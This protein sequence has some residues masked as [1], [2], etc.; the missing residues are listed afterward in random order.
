MALDVL[1]HHILPYWRSFIVILTP[2][3]FLPIPIIAGT[4]VNFNRS[5][6]YGLDVGIR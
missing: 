1:K 6:V 2:L 5:Y 4:K 3:A